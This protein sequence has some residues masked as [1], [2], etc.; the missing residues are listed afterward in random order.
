MKFRA[1]ELVRLLELDLLKNG[2]LVEL[3]VGGELGDGSAF[4]GTDC[5][6]LVGRSR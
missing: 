4:M 5:I 2:A 1:E 6:R 3:V